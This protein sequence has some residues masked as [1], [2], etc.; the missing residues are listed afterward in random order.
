MACERRFHL[1]QLNAIPA[2]FQ[3]P[4]ETAEVFDI[5]IREMPGQV[6]GFVNTSASLETEGI[7]HESLGS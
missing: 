1:S 7:R 3:L 5:P 6:S 4:V 2:D